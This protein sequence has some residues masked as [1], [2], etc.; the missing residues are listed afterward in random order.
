MKTIEDFVADGLLEQDNINKTKQRLSFIFKE[1]PGLMKRL[2]EGFPVAVKFNENVEN[3]LLE[4]AKKETKKDVVAIN[5]CY[6]QSNDSKVKVM[7][8]YKVKRFVENETVNDYYRS[9]ETQTEKYSVEKEFIREDYFRV[10]LFDKNAD[11]WF[12]VEWL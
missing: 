9:S 10:C 7:F 12:Q 1:D 3:E 11:K 6:V 5:K 4:Y 2:V 8:D